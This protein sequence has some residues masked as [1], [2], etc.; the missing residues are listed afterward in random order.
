MNLLT[1]ETSQEDP[2]AKGKKYPE[3]F[4]TRCRFLPGLNIL[5][6][7]FIFDD[8]NE[9]RFLERNSFGLSHC[10]CRAFRKLAPMLVYML[11]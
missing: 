8:L 4:S 3:A 1:T 10:V 11:T 9:Q 7:L 2:Q 6:L 5:I